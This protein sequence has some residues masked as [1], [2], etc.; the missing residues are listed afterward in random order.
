MDHRLRR[1][2]PVAKGEAGEGGEHSRFQS[3]FRGWRKG[4][5]GTSLLLCPSVEWARFIKMS[6]LTTSNLL[7]LKK[8]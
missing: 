8:V 6:P 1:L 2:L 7:I 3:T 5:T 4:K